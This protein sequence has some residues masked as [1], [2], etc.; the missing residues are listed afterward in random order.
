METEPG[1]RA[2]QPLGVVAFRR[3]PNVDISRCT[4]VAVITDSV[5]SHNEIFNFLRVE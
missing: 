3:Y 1:Q 4:R 5:A 2:N